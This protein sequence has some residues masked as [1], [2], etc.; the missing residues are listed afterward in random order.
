M[1]F[2]Q[3]VTR[4]GYLLIIAML[5]M[6]CTEAG[7]VNSTDSPVA[8]PTP[9]FFAEAAKP[10]RGLVLR[11]FTENT[12]P[13]HY[14]RDVLAPAF[15]QET[16]IKVE[17]E[18]GDN[19]HIEKIVES[20]G[21]PYDY[22][23]V[24]QDVIY[25]YLD[26]GLLVNLTLAL[27]ENPHL[28]SPDFNPVDFTEFI[29]E[30]KDPSTGDLYGVPVEA[31]VKIYVYRKDLFE[32]PN[33]QAEFAAEHNYPLAPAVTFTQYRDIAAFFTQYGREHNLELWGTAVQAAVGRTASFYEFFETIAPAFGVYNWG[34]NPDNYKAT[35]ANGGQLDGVRAKEALTFWV[36][37][38]RYAPPE[39][40]SST[41][42]EIVETVASGRVAQA[43]VY[44]EY[45]SRLAA[46]SSRSQ[47]VGKVGVAL[48]PTDP[49]IIE[50]AITGKGYIGY[51]DG[52]A[53]GI[54]INSQNKE[55]ALLWLQYLGQATVQPE[56]AIASGRIVHL[57]TFDDPLV[58]IQDEKLDGY[59]T[60]M[61]EQGH[62]FAGAPPFPFH[63][64]VRDVI[65][66]FI[67][68]AITG[69]LTP[70]QALDQAAI[71]VDKELVRLGFGQ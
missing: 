24:E 20:G 7:A 23:Y 58:Q 63:A 71:A 5:L 13:P 11:G 8:I 49:D 18:V 36:D 50:D 62:L 43:W 1:M 27:Q 22:V 64:S 51:Y 41:W 28:V 29:N 3:I 32:D 6:A 68:Q 33:I 69:E 40:T 61:K 26:K 12:P 53:F 19:L 17:V 2:T 70:E 45:V 39:A 60:L 52:A 37:M 46:D 31:F 55:A 56:W 54:P 38:L 48:P 25:G 65:M 35:V 44:G 10:Y 57:S 9:S 34:I 47:I 42:D 15:E 16:G 59:Y 4:S 21:G 30:F 66:P 14:V 67:H